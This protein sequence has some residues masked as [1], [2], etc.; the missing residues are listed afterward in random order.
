MI[1]AIQERIQELQWELLEHPPYSPDMAPNDFHLFGPLKYH[2]CGK[3][4]ADDEEVK[5]EVAE[6]TVKI[7]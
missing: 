2:L 6:T 7:L 3:G 5:M 4:F 1:R